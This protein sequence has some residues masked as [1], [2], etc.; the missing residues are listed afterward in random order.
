MLFS[1]FVSFFFFLPLD[2][3][4]F[5]VLL[6]CLNLHFALSLVVHPT[7]L[8][9]PMTHPCSVAQGCVMA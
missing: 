1:D 6:L 8:S 3:T 9:S 2:G 4:F 7:N 5:V